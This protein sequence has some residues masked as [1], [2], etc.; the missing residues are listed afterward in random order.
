MSIEQLPPFAELWKPHA[1]Q[2]KA[3]KFL[4]EHAAAAL[5]LEPGLG[6][7]SVTLGA[8][9]VL[10]KKG[11]LKKVLVIA[12]LRV[13][14]QVWPYEVAGWK[15]F[16]ELKVV[17][18]HGPDKV[19]RLKEEADIYVIN[20]EGLDWLLQA[21]KTTSVAKKRVSVTVDMKRWKKLGFDTLVVDEL[22][23]FKH[24]TSQRFKALKCILDTFQRRWGLTGS[25][26]TNGL[27]DLFGQCYILDQ[28]RSLGSFITHF[29][30][31]Y[32]N[33]GRDG[34]SWYL[35]EGAEEQIYERL[36]PLALRMAA[37][38]YLE[39]PKLIEH[40]IEVELPA[41]AR[42]TYDALEEDLIAML[43]NNVITAQNAGVASIKLRQLVAGGL[44]YQEARE[45]TL[46]ETAYVSLKRKW[47]NVHTAKIDALADLVEEL[48][49]SP[50]LIAYD[51]HH[52][53]DRFEKKFGK[54]LPILGAGVTPKRS[55]EL[56]DEWNKGNLPWLFAHP[57]SAG[58]GLNLQK[59]N[60]NHVCW[61][62]LTW[63]YELYDQFNRRLLRQ[64]N[65][66]DQVFVHHILAKDTIDQAMF[67]A[68]QRKRKGQ[69]A[70]FD[71]LNYLRQVKK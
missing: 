54:N 15:D 9:K 67:Y 36:R 32:F 20:P 61:H 64:G 57:M 29:R 1:Y 62:S 22:S 63:D 4:L 51:F 33:P 16:H 65:Q 45:P 21:E 13:C 23:K 71:A 55:A 2:K 35:K 40:R 6:K 11:L 26:A 43:E 31:K 37:E 27:M 8:I 46:D 34:F 18:L 42:K 24:T 14:Y 17:V 53:L 5:F 7:T 70:L 52:D 68:L 48:Q 50:L 58:H 60:A 30:F 56:I 39:L 41:A 38:D 49:G 12:P 69:Q 28:G 3:M 25:P 47:H 59:A 10:K 66:A 19:E 44:Y